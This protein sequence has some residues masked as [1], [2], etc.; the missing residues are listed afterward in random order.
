MDLC[1]LP[2]I[3]I[4]VTL[5]GFRLGPVTEQVSFPLRLPGWSGSKQTF[6]KRM[7]GSTGRGGVISFPRL[8]GWYQKL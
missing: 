1:P 2:G 3:D 7:G 4:A 6:T 8:G 5:V